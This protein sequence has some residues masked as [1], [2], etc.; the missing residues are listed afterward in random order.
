MPQ[1]NESI[2]VFIS[3][4]RDGGF[5]LAK[6]IYD[7][8]LKRHY[9]VFMDVHTLG[10]GDFTTTTLNEIRNVTTSSLS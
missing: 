6:N 2:S 9:D 7:D 5:Y 8:L 3:Y 4:R 10:A 1:K